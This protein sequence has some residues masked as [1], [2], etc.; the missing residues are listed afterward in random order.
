MTV[1]GSGTLCID[2]AAEVTSVAPAYAPG[3]QLIAAAASHP[4]SNGDFDAARDLP[5]EQEV[6]R[7][8][9]SIYDCS[10]EAELVTRH[11]IPDALPLVGP[12]HAIQAQ[13]AAELLDGRVAV[14]GAHTAT[15]TIDGAIRSGQRAARV[16]AD[17]VAKS[18]RTG[19]L[20]LGSAAVSRAR[21]HKNPRTRCGDLLLPGRDYAAAAS[22]LFFRSMK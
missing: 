7:D 14:A 4:Y 9:S 19:R 17:L 1:D 16:I 15:S 2:L 12:N 13:P 5:S 18:S 10:P 22:A 6:R 3:T 21:F 8:V 11:D 20:T